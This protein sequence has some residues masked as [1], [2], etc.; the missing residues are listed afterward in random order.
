[1]NRA[2]GFFNMRWSKSFMPTLKEKPKNTESP[3]HALS[4]KAGLVRPLTAGVYSYLPLCWKVLLRIIDIVRDEMENIGA[5]ELLLP[6]LSPSSLWQE[7]GRWEEYGGDMFKLKDRKKRD[8]SL[9]PTH[10]EIISEI[11]RKEIR[12][13]RDLPQIW[14]QIQLKFRDELRPR[15][16]VLRARQFIMKDSYSLDVDE[17]GLE[18]SYQLHRQAYTNIFRRCGL[19]TIIVRASS[20]IMGGS[21]SEE[22]MVFTP[23]GE[24]SI[25][26]CNNCEYRANAAVATAMPDTKNFPDES[27]EKVYTPVEGTVESISRFL[28]ISKKRIL[29][30]L[31]YMRGEEPIFVLVD[32]EHEV[33]NEKLKIVAQLRTATEEEIKRELGASAGYVGPVGKKIRVLADVSLEGKRGL[34][35]GAN[36]DLY[37]FRGINIERDIDV[38]E[39][40]DLR[41]V[42]DGD[43]C[44]ICGEEL[45]QERTIELGHIFKLGTRYSNAMGVT[46][47]DR[48]G[49]QFPVVMGSYGI[50]I[51]RIMAAVIE[52]HND[53]HGIIWPKELAP[54]LVLILPL[55]IQNKN[56]V[57]AAEKVYVELVDKEIS[58]LIDDRDESPGVKFKDGD[59]IG[60]PIKVIIGERSLKR[61][62]IEIEE[63]S[64][65]EI[66]KAKKDRVVEEILRLC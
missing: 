28:G 9:S 16:G 3:S 59:L 7:T 54:Y 47:F 26:V 6:V 48:S 40:L 65:K 10:E 42:K 20:G 18:N 58:V 63:R 4:I 1:M 38:D 29:K 27:L 39:Y 53:K 5:Q 14:Y 66:I 41:V 25:I 15:A 35:T 49:K 30:S 46:F 51:E 62:E 21:L 32:G 11:T 61:G 19:D 55:N 17:Q 37:H 24:D 36:K 43:K 34:I 45:S 13:Y 64:K 57:S 12:S 31:L 2:P 50:G 8:Y 52:T 33:S 23:Y 56:V 60:I 44:P 22:F